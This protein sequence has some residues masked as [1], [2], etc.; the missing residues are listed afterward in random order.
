MDSNRHASRAALARHSLANPDALHRQ[1]SIPPG[2][3]FAFPKMEQSRREGSRHRRAVHFHGCGPKAGTADGYPPVPIEGAVSIARRV[4]EHCAPSAHTFL[5]R[6]QL[7]DAE[8]SGVGS[9][10]TRCSVEDP[11]CVAR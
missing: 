8:R 6:P 9:V 11:V 1:K 2:E 10:Q 7:S 5:Q 3:T 4:E